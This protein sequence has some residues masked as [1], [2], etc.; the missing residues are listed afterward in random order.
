MDRIDHQTGD[1]APPTEVEVCPAC[2]ADLDGQP[3][4]DPDGRRVCG[5]CG[6]AFGPPNRKGG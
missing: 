5:A 1:A 6:A 4:T 2:G 3:V